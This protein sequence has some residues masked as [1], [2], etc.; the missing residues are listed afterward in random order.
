MAVEVF[1]PK[2]GMDMQEGTIIRWL[3]SVGDHVEEGD[4][5]LEIETDK[6]SMEVEAPASGVLLTKYFDDGS[7]VPVVTVIGYIGE[8]GEHVPDAPTMA[9]GQDR[10]E[11]EAALRKDSAK[12]DERDF[13]YRVAVIGSGPAGYMAGIRAGRMGAKTVLFEG[14][15]LGGTCTNVGCIPMK[16]YNNTARDIDDTRRIR[17]RGIVVGS[18]EV[19]VDMKAVHAFKD[20]V[21]ARMGRGVEALLADAGVEIVREEAQLIGPHTIRAGQKTYQAEQIILCSGSLAQTLTYPGVDQPEILI[22]DG[23]FDLTEVPERLVIV[24][25]GVIG[26]EMASSFNRFGAK[27]TVVE[28]QE[29]LVPTFDREV[30]DAVRDSFI[31]SGITVIN[32]GKIDHFARRDGH[33]VVVLVDGRELEADLV[34][35]AVG[36]KPNLACL[37]VMKDRLDYERGKIMVDEYCRTNIPHIFACGDISNRSIHAH[38][39]MKMGEAAASTACG[40]AKSTGLN[41]APLC[42]Y[43]IPEAAGIG[44]TESQARKRGDIMIGRYP[45]AYNGRAVA[46]GKPEGFVKVIADRAYGEILGVHI[47]GA[48]ACEMIVEAKTMM[49]MEITV[50]EVAE[51]MHPHPTFSEAFMEACADA[52]SDCLNLPRKDGTAAER[53]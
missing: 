51:I 20:S 37:G 48:A 4:P 47:V 32:G 45:F 25:G 17:E 10:A 14:K 9:G 50:Y 41:R 52:I 24:G 29:C 49:D 27:V 1:M 28:Q 21:T 39:A 3:A 38:S 36:R 19:R 44:L 35:Q 43:G 15:K 12:K 11:D 7:V 22:S 13:P 23:M 42:L 33:P 53:K 46:A 8:K 18:C 31:A 40:R 16:T 34:L 5:L 26:C 2:A 30:S 6:V